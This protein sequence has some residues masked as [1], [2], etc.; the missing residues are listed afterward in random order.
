MTP[1]EIYELQH[2]PT[3][4]FVYQQLEDNQSCLLCDEGLPIGMITPLDS[5]CVPQFNS[6]TLPW[7]SWQNRQVAAR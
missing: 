5:G 7:F 6:S 1:I 2:V 4:L 3:L